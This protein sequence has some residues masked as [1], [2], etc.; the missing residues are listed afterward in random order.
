MTDYRNQLWRTPAVRHLAWLCQAPSLIR[1]GPVRN[2]ADWLPEDTNSR[3]R[4]LDERPEPLMSALAQSQS[5]RLGHYF[6]ELYHFLL[7]W[8]LEWPVL[9]R[10]AAIRSN[11]GNTLGE[12]DFIVRN[13]TTGKLEHHEVAV[14][15][16]LGLRQQQDLVWYGPNARDR[17]DRKTRHMLS[18]QL[19]MTE[20][21][22]T[23]HYLKARNL[24]EP[25]TPVLVMPGYL[26][27]PFMPRLPDNCLEEWINPGHESGT[28]LYHSQLSQLDTGTWIPLRKPHW[29]GQ[30][31]QPLPAIP[32][33][34]SEILANV[35]RT[36]RPALFA[37]LEANR[38][39]PS[40]IESERWFVVPDHWPETS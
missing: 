4:Y 29:L 20:H 18:H 16:Y 21:P 9:V 15:F 34:T 7:V 2:L 6:E 5:H 38:D 25:I 11:E 13:Q 31:Q 3:L 14:K 39:W 27:K 17:L 28:W 36:G 37:R 12:L 33:E 35:P 24:D 30:C 26:F 19:T 1:S 40:Y 10:N 8:L 22:E 23:R 32:E